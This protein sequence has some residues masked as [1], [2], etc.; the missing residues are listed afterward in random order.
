MK[1]INHLL[2]AEG[3]E[4][5]ITNQQSPNQKNLITADKLPKDLIVHYTACSL[6]A[7]LNT[8]MASG[9]TSAHLVIALDGTIHQLVP[10]NRQ[11][12]H[13]GYSVWDENSAFNGRAVGIELVNFGWDV[14][15]PSAGLIP[16]EIVTVRHKHKFVSQ[17]KWHKYPQAQLDALYKITKLL[18]ETYGLQRI[19]GHDDISAGRKQD[20]GPAF[21]WDEYRT[22]LFGSANH[23]GKIFKVKSN[24]T[25][26]RASD[27]KNSTSL[28]VLPKGYEVGLIETWN[29]WSKVYLAN[30]ADEVRVIDNSVSPPK[31]TN[32]KKMGWIRSDLIELK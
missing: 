10:F 12:Y 15:A 4:V 17:T 11:A 21:P 9:S 18:L 2:V 13:A 19:L 26:L 27:T 5:I 30:T 14:T 24:G 6:T 25:N 8:F 1:I 3:S 20:P 28:K 32:I 22:E 31:V 29:N 16:E 23:I 7:A